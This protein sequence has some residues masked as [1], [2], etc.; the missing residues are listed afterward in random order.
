MLIFFST[1]F[2][3]STRSIIIILNV[4]KIYLQGRYWIPILGK[5]GRIEKLKQMLQTVEHD[6][7][8]DDYDRMAKSLKGLSG[9]DLGKKILLD[10]IIIEN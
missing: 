1:I 7:I 6:L 9:R 5:N 10:F 4:K 8:A 2:C 3:S